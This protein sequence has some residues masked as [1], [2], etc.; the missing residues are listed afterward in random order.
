MAALALAELAEQV[1]K[2]VGDGFA[3]GVIIDRA[4]RTANIAS[5]AF[6]DLFVDWTFR[7]RAFLAILS[8]T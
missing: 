1:E 6:A 2:I 5:A 8:A 4:Q 7:C 3:Q